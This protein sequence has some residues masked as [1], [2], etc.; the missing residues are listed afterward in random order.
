M[1][2]PSVVNLKVKSKFSRNKKL[3]LLWFVW[4]LVG[5][6]FYIVVLELN[7]AEGFYMAVNIGYSIGFG[8]IKEDGELISQIFSTFYVLVGASFVGAALGIFAEHIVA[9]KDKWYE[10]EKDSLIYQEQIKDCNTISKIWYFY[11]HKREKFR[12][13]LLWIVSVI[14]ATF[15]AWKSNEEFGFGNSVY[16]AVSALSTGGHY[17]LPGN[18]EPW[19]YALTAL[20]CAFGIPLMG[21]AMATIASFFI[22]VGSI[23]DTLKLMKKP[24]TKLEV[25]MLTEF[26]LADEDGEI[27]KSEFIILCM[28]R[29]GAASPELIKLIELYFNELDDD[30]SGTL[31]IDEILKNREQA[32]SVAAQ[33]LDDVKHKQKNRQSSRHYHHHRDDNAPSADLHDDEA[34]TGNLRDVENL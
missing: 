20:Y 14:I 2:V 30:N 4:L 28:V 12:P 3:I 16:F 10:K 27:D 9:D 15:A 26:G 21:V 13:V 33:L 24:V 22:R 8:D 6:C 19:V 5:T 11:L 31:S 18:N 7:I 25:D 17:A 32:N 23:E 29:T 34:K 1:S